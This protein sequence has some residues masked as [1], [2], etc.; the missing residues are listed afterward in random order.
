M[1]DRKRRADFG[2]DD[3][4]RQDFRPHVQKRQ[5]VPPVVQ[6]CKEMMPDI[7]TIGESAKAF[8]DDIKFL[9]EAIVNEYGHEEYFN[10]ALLSTFLAVVLEQPQK[11][12]A[13]SLLTIVVNA[14]NEVAGKSIVNFFYEKLQ[15]FCNDS[16]NPDLELESNDTGCWNKIKLIMRFLSLLSPILLV[17]DIITLYKKLFDLAIELNNLD[18]EKRNPLAEEIY[19][20]TMLNVPYLFYF[21]RSN[22]NLKEK[23]NELI[24]YVESNF[25][26]RSTNFD[27]LREYNF[28]SPY[29]IAELPQIVLPNVKN[30][31]ANGMEQLNQLFYDWS[32]LL[33]EQSGDQGFNDALSLPSIQDLQ[34]FSQLAG[35]N[36]G[37]VDSTWRTPAYIFHVYLPRSSGDFDTVVPIDTYAGQLFKDIYIDIVESLEFNRKEVAKQ[38]VSLNLFFKE[39]I[40]VEAGESI[41]DLIAAREEN[42]L[43]PTYKIEDLAIETVLSLVLKLPNISHPFAYFYALLVDICQNSPKAIAPVFGRAFRFF[44]HNIYKLDFELKLRFLDWF[45]IQMSNF[46]FSWKWNEWEND[47]VRFNKSFYNPRIT[48]IRNL[49]RKEL[50]LTSNPVDVDGSLPEEFK[51]YLDTSYISLESVQKFYQTLFT[52]FSVDLE[53]VRRNDLYFKQENVPFAEITVELLDYIHKQND[54]RTYTELE[55]IINKLKEGH[56]SI[57]PDFDRFVVILVTQ[58]VVHSGSRS[59][60]HANK[61]ISDL[62]ED[63]KTLFNSLQIDE[64]VKETAIIEAVMSYWNSNSQN[65][66]LIVDAFKFGGMVSSNSIYSFCLADLE[67]NIHGLTDVTAIDTIF[68]TLSQQLDTDAADTA[69]F[70]LV[71][72]KLCLIVNKTVE[73]LEIQPE[74]QIVIPEIEDD[75]PVDPVTEV[76]RLDL[77]WKYS[78]AVSFTKSLVRKYSDQFKLLNEKLSNGLEVAIPHVPTRNIFGKWLEEVKDL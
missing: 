20:N 67:G 50:R 42:L 56:Q 55:E 9:S 72:E 59:L 57:I 24:T 4:Y 11:Q 28:D 35:K 71:F 31:L 54:A 75:T 78:S 30:V 61:Y 21:S 58:A 25:T 69:D 76:P 64:S 16:T 53:D 65:G 41:A 34:P 38:M 52:D 19:T 6:L 3:E 15:K 45:S 7:C 18:S 39:G 27:I 51:Q 33:P 5:R 74:D 44:Y 29:N 66:F 63:L 62:Q 37:S 32:Y 8:E 22:E 43:A 48:F 26:I 14:G 23:T 47:S 12:P 2:E 73:E 13:I 49:I 40:F 46:N 70:E 10:N 1:S 68:R 17:D 60:S 77:M 36:I